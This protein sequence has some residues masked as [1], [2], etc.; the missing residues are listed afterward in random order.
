[1]TSSNHCAV[2]AHRG[3]SGLCGEDNTLTSFSRAI[4]LGCDYAETDLRLTADK[5]IICYHD[6]SFQDRALCEWTHS[7]LCT[8]SGLAVPTLDQLLA[9][10]EHRIGLDLELK[11]SGYEPDIVRAV[12]AYDFQDKLIFKS[13][14]A[15]AVRNIRALEHEFPVGVLIG[16]YDSSVNRDTAVESIARQAQELSVDF[17]S[18]HF[19]HINKALWDNETCASLPIL[20][21]TVNDSEDIRHCYSFP[22]AG[23]ISD[24]PDSCQAIAQDDY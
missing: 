8:A 9:F 7:E 24:R 22:I 12:A 18:P 20:P 3:A 19:S 13:F 6:G 14:S 11:E 10:C 1:M 2:I 4:A 15:D 21:W 5:V 17:I 16:A 23:I